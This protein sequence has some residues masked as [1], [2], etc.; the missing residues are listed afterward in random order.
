MTFLFFCR[1]REYH[2]RWSCTK[3]TKSKVITGPKDLNFFCLP[4]SKDPREERLNYRL[5]NWRAS[6]LVPARSQPSQMVSSSSQS[7]ETRPSGRRREK[8]NEH[9]FC[10]CSFPTIKFTFYRL[11]MPAFKMF[12]NHLTFNIL[13]LL[14][15]TRSAC[16]FAPDSHEKCLKVLRIVSHLGMIH[17]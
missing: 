9:G 13:C 4:S 14:I 2:R 6:L 10:F 5:V 3:V 8:I 17:R 7:D 12:C 16:T 1:A 15:T 11:L